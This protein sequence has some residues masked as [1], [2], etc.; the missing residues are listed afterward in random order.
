MRSLS[1][2]AFLL[3]ARLTL[4]PGSNGNFVTERVR[5]ANREPR[6]VVTRVANYKFRQARHFPDAPDGTRAHACA[7]YAMSSVF[8]ALHLCHAIACNAAFCMLNF[9][10]QLLCLA[11]MSDAADTLPDMATRHHT[12]VVQAIPFRQSRMC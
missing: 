5:L 7:K 9:A 3:T 4:G 11:L 2:L 10:S 6:A 1:R 8:V 12:H